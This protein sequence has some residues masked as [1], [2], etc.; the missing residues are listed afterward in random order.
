MNGL[1]EERRVSTNGVELNVAVSGRSSGP[2]VILLNGFPELWSARCK[3]IPALS[4]RGYWVWAPDQRGYNKSDKPR[5]LA[6]YGIDVLADDVV[7]LID[8]AGRKEAILVAHDWGAAVAW[9]VAQQF[10]DRVARLMVLSGP[11]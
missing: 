11:H 4:E 7:G 3:Q 1:V 5:G 10:P 9:R 6:H 2:L 8:A